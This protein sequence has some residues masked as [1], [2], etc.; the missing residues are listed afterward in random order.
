MK[1]AI[2][3]LFSFMGNELS[4]SIVLTLNQMVVDNTLVKW[5]SVSQ[6]DKSPESFYVISAPVPISIIATIA[7]GGLI[8]ICI[9]FLSHV[10]IPLLTNRRWCGPFHWTLLE[11][12]GF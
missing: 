4:I 7:S 6:P 2:N 11:N 9:L 12:V 1:Q 5:W 3:L 10:V 8:G